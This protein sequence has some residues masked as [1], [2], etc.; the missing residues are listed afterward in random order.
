MSDLGVVES[1]ENDKNNNKIKVWLWRRAIPTVGFRAVFEPP[2][3]T[4]GNSIYIFKFEMFGGLVRL[5]VARNQKFEM[6]LVG[7]VE[8]G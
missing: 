5:T 8:R 2:N 6:S 4:Y 7:V 3:H 1:G